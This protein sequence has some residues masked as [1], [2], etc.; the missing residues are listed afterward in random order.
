MRSPSPG[1]FTL[2]ELM[3]VLVLISLMVALV[4]P[5]FAGSLS[6]LETTTVS[7]KI[8]A[9]LRYARSRAVTEKSVYVAAFEFENGRMRVLPLA[10]ATPE[11][12]TER[13]TGDFDLYELPSHIRFMR[14]KTAQGEVYEGGR[15]FIFVFFPTGGSSGGELLIRDTDGRTVRLAAD[16]ITGA[17]ELI[18]EERDDA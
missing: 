12:E 6:R 18:P 1:G 15:P 13:V 16:I 5:R 11:D 2:L 7:R 9:G 10:E 8:A 14:G 3:V 17:V 4:V